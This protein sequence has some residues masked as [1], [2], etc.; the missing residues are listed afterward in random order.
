[1]MQ[2]SE[3]LDT[4][5]RLA[6]GA[7]EGDWRSAISRAYYGVFHFFRE[8]FLALGM[9]LGRGGQAHNNLYIG[10]HNCG[11]VSAAAIGTSVD[12]LRSSR[13]TADYVLNTSISSANA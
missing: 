8:F 6:Q 1:M 11:I 9:D 12:N 13:V 7:T 3:F 2:P 4:A 10:L 5:E